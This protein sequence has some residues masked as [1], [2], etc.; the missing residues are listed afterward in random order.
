MSWGAPGASATAYQPQ[1]YPGGQPAY[2]QQPP[3]HYGQQPAY[4]QHPPAPGPPQRPPNVQPPKKKGNPIITRYPPPPGY[5]GPAQPQGPFG[6][7]QYPNQFQPPQS[8]FG[9]SAPGPPYGQPA[10][11]P[12]A[13]PNQGYNAP[14]TPAYS[15]QGYGPPQTPNYPQQSFQQAQNYQ[16]PLHGYAPNQTYPQAQIHPGGQG[17]APPP[18]SNYPGYHTQSAP[19]DPN[20]QF[21]G[22]TPGWAQ[23]NGQGHYPPNHQYPPYNAPSQSFSQ[24]VPQGYDPNATP[25]PISAHPVPPQPSH[26]SSQPPSAMEGSHAGDSSS[27]CLESD[28]W[29]FDFEGAI[30]PKSNEPVDPAL[31]LGVIIWH[32]AKQ[33]TRAL[34]STFEEA[35]EQSLKPTPEKL[36]NGESVSMYFTAENSH[37]AFLD[38][39]QTDEWETIRDDPI[40]VIF[41]DAEM[42]RNLVSLEDC[43]GQRDR[44]DEYFRETRRDDDEEMPDV[45]WSV[46][47]NLEQVLSG[48]NGEDLQPSTVQ[49]TTMCPPAHSQEDILAKLGVTGAPKPPSDELMVLPFPSVDEAPRVAHPEKPA[50]SALPP[51]DSQLPPQIAKFFG[52]RRESEHDRAPQRPYGSISSGNAG[53]FP[54]PPPPPP[55]ESQRYGAWNQP[56]YNGASYDGSRGSPAQSE[57]SNHTMAGSDFEPEKPSTSTD[58]DSSVVPTIHR[59][60]SSFSRKRSY[61][62]ADHGDEKPRQQDDHTKRKRRAQVD[63]AYSRR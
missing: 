11:T 48:T 22:Q 61:E 33:V 19:V 31:S 27:L 51:S 5:R 24:G 10:P 57:G 28:D 38:V 14:P 47:D 50:P 8:G 59:S 12:L 20:Q 32:P 9:Q 37:E 26:A 30:W 6:A 2:G 16:W 23:P 46:M 56:Q 54:P 21:H 15:P 63:A 25:T 3:F 36:D 18:A 55:P 29:D 40:F 52:G 39:R 45:S 1:P 41:T 4:G 44:L 42:H 60:D 53:R 43:I 49:H 13:Y 17:Y 35:E 58:K 34:P 7:N 62:D